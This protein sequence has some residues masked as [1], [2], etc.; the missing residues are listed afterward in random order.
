MSNLSQMLGF[1]APVVSLFA[2]LIALRGDTWKSQEVGF[3]RLTIQGRIALLIAVAACVVGLLSFQESRKTELQ[4]SQRSAELR[5]LAHEKIDR[6]R[7]QIVFTFWY[8]ALSLPSQSNTNNQSSGTY[9]MLRSGDVISDLST[10]DLSKPMKMD[11][12]A[13]NDPGYETTWALWMR[14][15]ILEANQRLGRV[16]QVFGSHLDVETSAGLLA[17]IEAEFIESNR[18]FFGDSYLFEHTRRTEDGATSS[19]NNGLGPIGVS[20]LDGLEKKKIRGQVSTFDI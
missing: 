15:N 5:H 7:R 20:R 16:L 14:S 19:T 6:A 10:F 17:V 18:E 13:A 9:D 11:R 12:L 8:L 3:K 4:L 1:V 2:A